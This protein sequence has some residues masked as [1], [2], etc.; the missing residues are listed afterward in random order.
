MKRFSA[1]IISIL[2]FAVA[3]GCNADTVQDEPINSAN[4]AT[5]P[6]MLA[7]VDPEDYIGT[8]I[9][10]A[11]WKDPFQSERPPKS[12]EFEE[13]YGIN[14]DEIHI[15]QGEYVNKIAA[16][17][18]SNSQ[19]DI[20]FENGNFPG[21][22]TVMQPI[23]AAKL[24]LTH[25]KWNQTLLDVSSLN[26]HP[27]L[28]DSTSNVYTETD[29]CVYNKKIF[30]DNNITTPSEYYAAGKWTFANFR[31][32]A[33]EVSEIST[34]HFIG[35]GVLS[36]VMLGAAGCSF[37]LYNDNKISLGVDSHLEEV[38]IFMSQM[39]VDGYLKLDRYGFDDGKQG[40]CF[41]NAFGL[42]R[43]GY[44][45]HL[46]PDYVG[47]TYLPVWK[48]GDKQTYTAIYRGWGLVE[49]CKNPVGAGL[50]L[51]YYYD[52]K[53]Q[54][55]TDFFLNEEVS[56][57]FF[58]VTKE[59]SDNVIYYRCPDM[60]KATGLGER[61]DYAFMDHTPSEIKYYLESQKPVM[62]QMIDKANQIIADEIKWIKEAENSGHLAKAN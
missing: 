23:D 44:F 38:F 61:F 4:K 42:Q 55:L 15:D 53:N 62:N 13:L 47:V 31:E 32:L 16:L 5:I 29:F 6:G 2:F 54:Y 17:I 56:D 48:E 7:E 1:L 39:R 11:S 36:E 20:F 60:M 22:L 33:K 51:N 40:M 18:A 30:S 59:F 57:F 28:I 41:T 58:K 52:S 46:N 10:V 35:A 45:T 3:V 26:G 50:F 12:K 37:F 14:C 34:E 43:R 21:S 24:D 8:T 49:G 19:P 25:S 9:T 27:Y